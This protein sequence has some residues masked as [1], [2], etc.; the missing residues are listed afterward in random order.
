MVD[1]QNDITTR[2]ADEIAQIT[3]DVMLEI[4]FQFVS[5]QRVQSYWDAGMDTIN[6]IGR[7]Q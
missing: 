2:S 5:N 1:R 6:K 3:K 7:V 4:Y